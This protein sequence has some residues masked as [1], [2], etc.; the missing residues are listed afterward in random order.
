MT[1][2]DRNLYNLILWEECVVSL[3]ITIQNGRDPVYSADCTEHQW[4]GVRRLE[5]IE[6]DRK[7]FTKIIEAYNEIVASNVRIEL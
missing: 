5:V 1:N 4:G 6:A 7:N 2:L 3:I